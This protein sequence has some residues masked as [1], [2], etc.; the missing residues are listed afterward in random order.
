MDAAVDWLRQ[1]INAP[2]FPPEDSVGLRYDLG[3]ML[4]GL[5]RAEEAKAEFRAVADID[6]EY[7]DIAA[8]LG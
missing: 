6:P 3:E 7:R 5:G 8:K 1:G 4:A 2:G